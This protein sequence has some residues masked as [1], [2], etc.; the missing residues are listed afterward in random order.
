MVPVFFFVN[1]TATTEIYTLSLHDALPIW[2]ERASA[3]I[4]QYLVLNFSFFGWTLTKENKL[5]DVQWLLPTC[6]Y[7]SAHTDFHPSV[8]GFC[9]STI[10]DP[11]LCRFGLC[12]NPA[13]VKKHLRLDREGEKH[14]PDHLCRGL[15]HA[16]HG[17]RVR[18]L[19]RP[20]LPGYGHCVWGLS[21]L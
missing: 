21:A 7:P 3:A 5:Y 20:P 15:L 9:V 1:D 12:S 19:W 18:N 14:I 10:D 16:G 4:R 2:L 8:C 6:N 11:L 13:D 17:R